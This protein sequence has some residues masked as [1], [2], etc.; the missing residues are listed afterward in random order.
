MHTHISAYVIP[1][2]MYVQL[3]GNMPNV[4]HSARTSHSH[5]SSMS[6]LGENS[7]CAGCKEFTMIVVKTT[8]MN[9]NGLSDEPLFIV[10]RRSPSRLSVRSHCQPMGLSGA[11]SNLPTHPCQSLNPCQHDVQLRHACPK[12]INARWVCS[13]RLSDRA[14]GARLCPRTVLCYGVIVFPRGVSA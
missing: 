11:D 13:R 1:V 5:I 2:D 6:I 9:M 7:G 3:I 4:G 8:D 10:A 14:L 12:C